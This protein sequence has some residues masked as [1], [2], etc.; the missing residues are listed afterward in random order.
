MANETKIDTMIMDAFIRDTNNLLAYLKLALRTRVERVDF[1]STIQRFQD[2]DEKL[3][4]MTRC[5]D[6]C[7]KSKY[8]NTKYIHKDIV[9]TY[10]DLANKSLGIKAPYNITDI[11]LPVELSDS[12][13]F[14]LCL[15]QLWVKVMM[16]KEKILLAEAINE[17]EK[18]ERVSDRV[19]ECIKTSK[20]ARSK[21]IDIHCLANYIDLVNQTIGL[22]SKYLFMTSQ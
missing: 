13:D 2:I 5:I 18:F 10:I 3:K 19:K 16:G 22:E 1:L 21:Y 4:E 9:S 7:K 20:K 11:A 12:P 14:L 17:F 8:F 6:M 15:Q